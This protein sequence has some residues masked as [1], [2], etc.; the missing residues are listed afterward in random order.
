MIMMIMKASTKK[1]H[2]ELG[3]TDKQVEAE[4]SKLDP[5]TIRSSM[6]NIATSSMPTIVNM[7]EL[8]SC[9]I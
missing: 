7:A 1:E 3:F 9:Q 6:K 4:A 5:G 8:S 2:P